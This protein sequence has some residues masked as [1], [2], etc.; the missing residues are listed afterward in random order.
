MLIRTA[1]AQIVLAALLGGTAL[2][3]TTNATLSGTILD[4]SGAAVPEA[5]VTVKNG[6]T[7]ATRSATADAEGRY[8]ISSL[9]PGQY[10]VRAERMGFRTAIQRGVVLA[11]GGLTT[12]N[13]TVQVGAINE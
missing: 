5:Q 12:L 10:E 4:P 8:S 7:G 1:L 13:L 9:P 6:D 2:G 11:V 3:Q